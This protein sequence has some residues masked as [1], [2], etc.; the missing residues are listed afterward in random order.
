[1]T[2]VL[3]K[4]T[5]KVLID[6]YAALQNFVNFSVCRATISGTKLSVLGSIVKHDSCLTS[7]RLSLTL[8]THRDFDVILKENS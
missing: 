5:I 3:N 8:I 1:M 6:A 4:S 7:D 2:F